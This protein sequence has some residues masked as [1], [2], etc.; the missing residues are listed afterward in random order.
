MSAPAAATVAAAER[1]MSG[2]WPKSWTGD[3]PARRSRSSI[4]SSSLHVFGFS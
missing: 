3:R 1:M 2:S 4:R